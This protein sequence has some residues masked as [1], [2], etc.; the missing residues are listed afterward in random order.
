[1]D[2]LLNNLTR[3]RA[4][5]ILLVVTCLATLPFLGL[6]DFNTKGEPREAV[7]A[8]TMLEHDDWI[9]PVNNGGEIPYKPPFFHWC[10]AAASLLDGGTVSEYTSRLPSAVA[11]IAMTLSVFAFFARRRGT[12]VGLLT[13]LVTFTAFEIY[14]A[15]MN[16][17]VDMVLTALMV[18]A[19]FRLYRWGM[20][21]MRGFPWLAI[22]LMSCATLT[23]GPVGILIP[24]LVAGIFLLLRGVPFFKAFIWLCLWGCLSLL[25]PLAWYA[26]AYARGGEE[27]L[28]LVMEENFGRMTGTMAYDSHL[29]PW[30]Y[31][32][33]TLAAGFLPW[34]VA[35]VMSLFIVPRA[36]WRRAGVAWRGA[37]GRLCVWIRSAQPCTLLSL[38]AAVVIFI[39]YCIPASKRSVYLMPMYPF[40]AY[41]IA[42]LLT[43]MSRRRAASVKGFGDFIAGVGCALL[44]MFVLVK[45]GAVPDS[46][47]GHGKHAAQNAAMLGSLREAGGVLGWACAV[48]PA[49][50]AAIWWLRVRRSVS[51][52]AAPTAVAGLVVAVY[53]SMS[54]CYQPAVLQPKSVKGMAADIEREFPDAKTRIYEFISGAEAAKGNPLHYFELN[55][56]MGDVVRNFRRE[57]PSEGYLL[58]E[59]RDMDEYGARFGAEG[60]EFDEVYTPSPSMPRKTPVL[61]RFTRR[62]AK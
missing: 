27:F 41:F 22:L 17:R 18:G 57:R 8:Y 29:N 6:A 60:Y 59:R 49:A 36:A 31:N 13:A 47:F 2:T 9:L 3:R 32:L 20:D 1:M 62:G 33:V 58:I 42:E 53:I 48:V 25:L 10:V 55:F 15:G 19:V 11:L 14:R 40:T 38:T 28:D 34:T 45:C 26:A 30:Y 7:V 50:C 23:K 52:I 4:L 54:G 39:F 44:L 43:W 24:C 16:C 35:V 5:L 51:G 21:G 37:W 61:Y 56:Y 12:A 46:I